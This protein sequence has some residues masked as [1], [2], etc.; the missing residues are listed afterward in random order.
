MSQNITVSCR[1]SASGTISGCDDSGPVSLGSSFFPHFT[2]K[3]A[4]S[5][6]FA[7]QDGHSRWIFLPHIMQYSAFCGLS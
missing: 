1:L 6:K 5:G 4:F 3:R 2:Q 7:A